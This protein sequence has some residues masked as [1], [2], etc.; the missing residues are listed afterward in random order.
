M[1]WWSL[2]LQATKTLP[3]DIVGIFLNNT[4]ACVFLA[5]G[6]QKTKIFRCAEYLLSY[7]HS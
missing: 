6:V 5:N 2:T 1:K 4:R 7:M 3:S